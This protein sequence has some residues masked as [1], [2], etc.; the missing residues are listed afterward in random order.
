M[1]RDRINSLL[2]L[3]LSFV[4]IVGGWFIMNRILAEKEDSMMK[5][6]GQITIQ[7]DNEDKNKSEDIAGAEK[8]EGEFEGQELSEK[9]MIQVLKIWEAGGK[10]TPHEPLGS[11]MNME[12]AVAKGKEWIDCME[13][14]KMLFSSE[15]TKEMDKISAKLCTFS[16]EAKIGTEMISFWEVSFLKA[17]LQI[18]FK[19]H[20]MSGEI[21]SAEITME[22][23]DSVVQILD[24]EFLAAAFPFISIE[25]RKIYKEGNISY[26]QN[27]T[28][29]LYLMAEKSEIRINSSPPTVIYKLWLGTEIENN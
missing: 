27:N 24:E 10:E 22:E 13:T 7:S 20:A 4:V 8:E 16:E 28:E 18:I 2:M 17:N 26:M 1:S 25:D 21:W 14:R 3:F 5:Q 11:Q 15:T 29:S 12:Q 6:M 9:E 19:I 23:K